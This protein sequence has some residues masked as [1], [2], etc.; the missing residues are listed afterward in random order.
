MLALASCIFLD[1]LLHPLEKIVISEFEFEFVL[2]I[3]GWLLRHKMSHRMGRKTMEDTDDDEPLFTSPA[4][5][6]DDVPLF[7]FPETFNILELFRES[8]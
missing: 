5:D 1:G 7:I 6:D 3:W 4:K 8:A 2:Y